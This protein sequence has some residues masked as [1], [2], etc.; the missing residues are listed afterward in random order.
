[1]SWHVSAARFCRAYRRTS[2]STPAH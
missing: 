1:M 2:S